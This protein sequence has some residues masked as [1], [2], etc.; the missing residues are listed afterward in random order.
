MACND[1]W[2]TLRT[3]AETGEA[4][5]IVHRLT[6]AFVY[7]SGDAQLGYDRNAFRDPTS[8]KLINANS[9]YLW[10]FHREQLNDGSHVY[11]IQTH[12]GFNPETHSQFYMTIDANIA[13]PGANGILWQQWHDSGKEA[14]A[15]RWHIISTCEGGIAFVPHYQ[16]ARSYT[17][18]IINRQVVSVG[19]VRPIRIF[20]SAYIPLGCT[21]E[22]VRENEI[23]I[24]AAASSGAA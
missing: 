6:G 24:V 18:G 9:H 11:R 3:A 13:D 16:Y 20:Y 10:R 22:I 19:C 17:L 7:N 14:D 5:M 2:E 8:G 4:V 12:V 23:D 1:S 21:W 15:Q